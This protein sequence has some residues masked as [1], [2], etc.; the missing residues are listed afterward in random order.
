MADDVKT[1]RLRNTRTGVVVETR[2]DNV[3]GLPVGWF[4][5]ESKAAAKKAPSSRSGDGK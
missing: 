1:V 2:E 5:P 4:E 3:A